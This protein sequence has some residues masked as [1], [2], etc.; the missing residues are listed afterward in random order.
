MNTVTA[1]PRALRRAACAL[2]CAAATATT[3]AAP[4]PNA[5]RPLTLTAR[6][7]PVAAFLQNLFASV[8]VPAVISPQLAGSVNGNFSGPAERVLRDV[9]RVY[10]LVTYYDGAAMH[11]VPAAE[12]V[13]R[14][15]AL[16]P[17]AAERV[18]REAQA[19]GLP[20]ARNTLRLTAGSQ[21]VISGTKRFAEQVDELIR[22]AQSVQTAATAP[23]VPGQM[24]F[25]VF[26]L[27]YAWAQDTTVN[28]GGRQI[29]VPGVASILRSL[30][31]SRP[32]GA[33]AQDVALRPTLPKLK[34][35]GLSSQGVAPTSAERGKESADAARGRAVDALVNALNSTAAPAG[36]SPTASAPAGPAVAYDPRQVT[37]E[38]EPRLN[39]IIVRDVAERLVRY[40]QLIA[41]LD[42]EPQSLEIE[43]TIIDVNTDRLRELGVNWRWN[44][45]GNSASFGNLAAGTLGRGGVATT[46]LGSLGQFIARINALQAEGAA[47]VVSSPQVVTLSNVEAV[48]DNTSTFFVRVAGREEVDL[49]NVSAGTSL[50]VTPHVFRDQDATRIKLLVNVEDGSLTGR[51]VDQIPIVERSSINTQALIAEGESLLIG[52]MTREVSSANVD[53]VPGLGDVPVVGNLF[54]NKTSSSA[55]IERMFLITPRLASSR[56]APTNTALQPAVPP[57]A[58]APAAGA[59]YTPERAPVEIDLDAMSPGR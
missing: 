49:F 38:A 24:D 26:Y 54:K 31:G 46:V 10:N 28:L 58:A 57:V 11:V 32:S 56:P 47:R 37:I 18:M 55:R 35:Q 6:E 42:V 2:L 45:A 23:A 13:N 51:Q 29:V 5:A 44:N 25:K 39:A 50:R 30:V 33:G 52:G 41:A 7:Q 16:A 19:L 48:F 4:M 1:L 34:G 8:D 20:D 17:A 43:A 12:L 53:K 22:A 9:A 3:L 36:E 40:E 27:R 59:R 14:S 21:L 15:Q